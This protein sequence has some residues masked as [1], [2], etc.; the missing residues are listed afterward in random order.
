[1]TCMYQSVLVDMVHAN[2]NLIIQLMQ[3][4]LFPLGGNLSVS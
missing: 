3:L 2:V 4:M 1:M